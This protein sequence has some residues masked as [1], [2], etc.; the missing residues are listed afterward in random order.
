VLASVVGCFLIVL[1][2]PI[3]Y[4]LSGVNAVAAL[5]LNLIILPG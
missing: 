5:I 3:Y 1:F 4:R 2:M